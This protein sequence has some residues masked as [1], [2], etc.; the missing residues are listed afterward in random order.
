MADITSPYYPYIK[1]Q[2]GYFNF[3]QYANFPRKICDYLIDAP[4]GEY[5]PPDDNK[6][7]RCRLWKYLFY[8]GAKPLNEPL[9]SIS[10]KMSVLFNPEKASEPPTEKGYRLV[11]QEYIKQSQEDAMTRI[12]IYMGR[13]IASANENTFVTSVVFDVFT[14]YTYELNTKSDEYSRTGAIIAA[15][16]EALHGVNIEGVGTFSMSKRIHPDACTRSI[17]DGNTNVGQELI[18]GLEM[19]STSANTLNETNNMPSLGN[20]LKLF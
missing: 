19:S 9:P 4:K 3:D 1:V 5:I 10:E 11:P 12:Y 8:D 16:I 17:F 14:H 2:D 7:P 15:L 13:S 6:Y 18:I 20:N